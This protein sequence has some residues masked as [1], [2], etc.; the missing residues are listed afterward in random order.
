MFGFIR[1]RF[2]VLVV[3]LAIGA[4]AMPARAQQKGPAASLDAT[5]ED[6]VVAN[7]VLANQ[8]VLDAYG[9]VSVRDPRDPNHFLMGRNLAPALVT[10]ADIVTYDFD[11]KPIGAPANFT[12]FLERFLH[13]EIYRARP[14]VIAIVH[15]H[16]PAV[17]PF[18][19]STVALQ[20]MYHM[21]SFLSPGVPVFEIRK[22]G[23]NSTNMLI[24]NGALGKALAATL[25]DKNVALMRGHGDVV[26]AS[27]LPMAVFR[28]VYTETNA[29]LELQAIGIGGPIT[30]LNK[31]EGTK[32]MAV[33]EQIHTRAWELWKR[34]ALQQIN[35]GK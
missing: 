23:G 13:G 25:A 27:S 11:G 4:F 19:D 5:V 1:A 7:R 21:A 14:D 30:F 2:V 31:D 12:H 17:I 15:S 6:L 20:P 16:S 26:V 29:R 3:L 8:Q 34:D 18:G 22:A 9:H 32:A 10:S 35:A 33:I 28:A 24:S